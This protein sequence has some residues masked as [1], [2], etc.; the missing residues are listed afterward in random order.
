MTHILSP[1][2]THAALETFT[3]EKPEPLLHA[4]LQLR[5]DS[6]RPRRCRSWAAGARR[7]MPSRRRAMSPHPEPTGIWRQ[8]RQ[9]IK[10]TIYE[11]NEAIFRYILLLIAHPPTRLWQGL[12]HYKE[13]VSVRHS[14]APGR[15]L[16]D[17]EEVLLAVV[18]KVPGVLPLEATG[19]A[20]VGAA[21]HGL[22]LLLVAQQQHTA[23]VPGDTLYEVGSLEQRVAV[24]WP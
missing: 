8:F 15:C 5:A 7:P 17:L 4:P 20:G 23:V 13:P 16:H 9:Y 24:T 21:H 19:Q 14:L 2:V 1:P 12:R 10:A 6:S 3:P 22:H 11:N 18:L